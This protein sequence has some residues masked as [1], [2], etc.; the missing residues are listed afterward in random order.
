MRTTVS[1]VTTKA[2][3]IICSLLLIILFG[4]SD[5]DSGSGATTTS[6]KVTYDG[7]GNTKGAV[8]VDTAIYTN[9]QS[10]TV[11]GNL[12]TLLKAGHGFVGWTN[13]AGT[14]FAPGG[15]IPVSSAN[16][17]LYA[18]W[19]I[20]DT[21]MLFGK[22][23]LEMVMLPGGITFPSGENDS[24]QKT[25][26]SPYMIGKYEITYGQ[27]TNVLIWA[28]ANKGYTFGFE[29]TNGYT[30]DTGNYNHPV[31]AI[32]WRDAMV[33]CNALT[34]YYNATKLMGF[35]DLVCVYQDNGHPIR[36]SAFSNTNQCDSVIPDASASGFRLP[37]DPEWE[38]AARY[39][40]DD[41]DGVLDKTGE[42]YPGYYPSGSDV[43]YSQSIAATD[44]DGNGMLR[45]VADV[46]WH[47][48]NSGGHTAEVG[49]LAPN[50][51]G[52]YDM[53][54]N[55]MEWTFNFTGTTRIF[56]RGGA[57]S[58]ASIN[59]TV[60]RIVSAN[61]YNLSMDNSLRVVRNGY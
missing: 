55:L 59:S 24:S 57:F 54:G 16:T 1:L 30:T 27:W 4:C 41:G 25:I 29:G 35:S 5:D 51:L 46:S 15:T 17:V 14:A 50:S 40:S 48:A 20:S 45:T 6:Y 8:P 56:L 19:N 31:T 34:E 47:S 49:L 61:A 13:A 10:A 32:T 7:N 21:T 44:L 28:K 9:N 42:Y 3:F 39:I 22:L 53:M 26:S 60:G 11:M 2:F 23:S 18:K 52:M 36:S 43:S 12:G 38:L 33:W 58:S 37:Q